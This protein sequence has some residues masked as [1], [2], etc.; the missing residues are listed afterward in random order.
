MALSL[1]LFPSNLE[2]S[3][4]RGHG[5][6]KQETGALG[7]ALVAGSRWKVPA[8]LCVMGRAGRGEARVASVPGSWEDGFGDILYRPGCS[9]EEI[10]KYP[11]CSAALI[12]HSS[13]K[14]GEKGIF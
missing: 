12:T 2:G 3:V 8:W 6:R 5:V 11:W 7:S 13:Q 9:S 4:E 14:S 1:K 10:N